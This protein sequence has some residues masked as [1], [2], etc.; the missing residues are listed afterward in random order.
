M[1]I[2]LSFPG[3]CSCINAYDLIKVCFIQLW[4][5]VQTEFTPS[6]GGKVFGLVWNWANVALL[7]EYLATCPGCAPPLAQCQPG[8]AP[9]PLPR[10][11]LKEY[12]VTDNLYL[13]FAY[14]CIYCTLAKAIM[15][16]DS[17]LPPESRFLWLY[18]IVSAARV[19]PR[20]IHIL[21]VA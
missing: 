12:A 14:Y 20:I 6:C 2:C 16:T 10:N 9:A 8:S 4:V 1:D 15:F 13:H 5:W 17:A 11:P 7:C 18:S 21:N 19:F 3:T